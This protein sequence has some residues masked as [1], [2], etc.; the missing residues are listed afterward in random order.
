MTSGK[1]NS[2]TRLRIDSD[3]SGVRS[4]VFMQGCPLNCFWCCNPE[5]RQKVGYRSLSPEG[6]Y[7]YIKRDIPYFVYS[8]GGITFSGGEPLWQADFIKEFGEMY[9]K[10]FS[11]DIETS[12]YAKKEKLNQTLHLID[13]WNVD[14]KVVDEQEHVKLTGVSNRTILENLAFLADHV[15]PDRIIITLPI[16]TK[17]NDAPA[18]ILKVVKL[19]KSI[20]VNCVEIHPYRKLAEEKQRRLGMVTTSVEQ[21]SMEKLDCI[22]KMLVDNGMCIKNRGFYFGKEKCKYLS[23]LREEICKKNKLPMKITECKYTGECI[24]T[25]PK[26]EIELIKISEELDGKS[27]RNKNDVLF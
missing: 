19:L 23:S 11:V 13:V 7:H 16:I 1:I 20:G 21:L 18:Q 5:T 24:G 8:N 27:G 22:E 6:L 17:Y 15:S 12:L 3:G 14:M 25:C 10:G 4:V 2:I 26:C 9:G